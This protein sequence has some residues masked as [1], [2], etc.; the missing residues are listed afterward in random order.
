MEAT[1]S[2]G[3]SSPPPNLNSL[4][5]PSYRI[6]HLPSCLILFTA[7]THTGTE[8]TCSI[9]PGRSSGGTSTTRPWSLSFL[10]T[11]TFPRIIRQKPPL[12]KTATAIMTTTREEMAE[13]SR[14]EG[15]GLPGW[16]I[17]GGQRSLSDVV[18]WTCA[19]GLLP[20]GQ[21]GE[22]VEYVQG[23]DQSDGRASRYWPGDDGTAKTAP[24]PTRPLRRWH[25]STVTDFR[26]PPW[27]VHST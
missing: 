21:G 11:A 12:N 26:W 4:P 27:F 13:D 2:Q 17:W 10:L 19:L 7:R 20:I 14:R 5:D 18:T 9:L 8:D 22:V 24:A 25:G 23:G 6:R 1:P 16:G 15:G 3:Q